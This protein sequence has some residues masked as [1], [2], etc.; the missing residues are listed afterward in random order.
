MKV[1]SINK[2][3]SPTF[4][5]AIFVN[6]SALEKERALPVLAEFKKV[7][8]AGISQKFFKAGK[9]TYE[10]SIFVG[11]NKG[12]NPDT[13]EE[14]YGLL[15]ATGCDKD[16]GKLLFSKL[17]MIDNPILKNIDKILDKFNLK[18]N[19][20]IGVVRSEF[21]DSSG[22]IKRI[23]RDDIEIGVTPNFIYDL[24]DDFVQRTGRYYFAEEEA[25]GKNVVYGYSKDKK[26][27]YEHIFT[28]TLP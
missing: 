26:G 15:I 17:A 6:L 28:T 8:R 24:D 21:T 18:H 19:P 10:Q 5:G 3:Q 16:Y 12:L 9:D 27:Q 11:Y 23:T 1:N 25:F 7:L 20:A 14:S 13:N 22:F 4:N 2:N